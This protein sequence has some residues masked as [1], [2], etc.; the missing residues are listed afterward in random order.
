M[1]TITKKQVL[2]EKQF[3]GV[4]YGNATVLPF[5]FETNASGVYGNTDTTTAVAR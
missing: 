3:G 2:T 4:P 1:A 5:S